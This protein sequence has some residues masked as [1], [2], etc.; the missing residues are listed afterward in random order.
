MCLI[1]YIGHRQRPGTADRQIRIV[2]IPPI[3]TDQ[4]LSPD[5][6][7]DKKLGHLT[8]L[9]YHPWQEISYGPLAKYS[10]STSFHYI[11]SSPDIF[12]QISPRFVF[13][14]NL[15]IVLNQA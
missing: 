10:D 13:S 5:C 4:P 15:K 12:R 7:P 1:V 6:T 2:Y 8:L 9:S 11:F 14:G 3:I